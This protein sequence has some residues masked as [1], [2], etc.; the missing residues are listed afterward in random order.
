MRGEVSQLPEKVKAEGEDDAMQTEMK[1]WFS[2]VNSVKRRFEQNPGATIPE[3]DFLLPHDWLDATRINNL[4]T[5]EDYRRAMSGLRVQAATRFG[6]VVQNA[7]RHYSD[8]NSGHFPVN[9]SELGSYLKSPTESVVLQRYEI[10]PAIYLSP[11]T[12]G[13]GDWAI[14]QKAASDEQADVRIAI[15][16]GVIM[17]GFR[18]EIDHALDAAISAF[19]SAHNGQLPKSIHDLKPFVTTPEEQAA[20]KKRLVFD[21]NRMPPPAAAPILGDA[22]P[23]QYQ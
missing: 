3:M 7:L 17:Q 12:S 20:L 8:A 13:L 22:F 19:S 11:D 18:S 6:V 4:E 15:G 10:F 23:H 9:L 2:R 5:D 1:S 14:I 21:S 16:A